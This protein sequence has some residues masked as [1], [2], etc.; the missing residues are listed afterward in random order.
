MAERRDYYEILGV[1][2][3][4][5][6]ATLKSA[7]RKLALQF[8]PDR[9][10]NNHDAAE[11]FKEASEAYAVLSD[12][13]KRDRYDRFGHAGFSG[14]PGFGA[15]G[16]DPSVFDLSDLLGGLFGFAGSRGGSRA[17][18]GSDL[19]YRLRLTLRDA[20]FGTAAPVDI[21]RL[22]RCEDCGGSGAEKGSR[23]RTCPVCRGSGQQRFL[24]G[25]LTIAR[26]CGNCRGEG[27]II[28][29][30]CPGCGG[31]GRRRAARTLD[32]K[33]PAGVVTN[34]RLRLAGEGDAGPN[35][36]PPGDLYVVV[37]VA[38]D[39]VFA[40]EGDDLVLH[41]DLPFPTLAL[42]GEIAVPTLEEEERVAIAAG[43]AVGSEVRL[44][45][46][47]LGR[48]GR[49]GRGDL[50]VRVGVRVPTAPSAEEKELL[51]RYAE[52]TGAPVGGARGVL[53]KAKKIFS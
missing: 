15:G 17:A 51:R 7:Y 20:A 27:S 31:A 16:F 36:G 9:N 2:R 39:E 5:G 22:E 44:R 38:E 3:D 34:S 50:V 21:K 45:G 24:Q 26:P 14:T 1:A 11:S 8:H 53:G 28:E 4:A 12:S 35:G 41:L 37:E 23:P 40:R 29:K 6:E 49:R 32:I 18:G 10:P 25:F 47:G 43:T 19:M 48:L 46:K 42:G 52:L 33:I 13:E 30:P